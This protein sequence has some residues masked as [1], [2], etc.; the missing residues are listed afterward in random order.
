[1]LFREIFEAQRDQSAI[2]WLEDACSRP[3]ATDLFVHGS[4]FIFDQF[5]EPDT[6]KG[7]LIFTSKLVDDRSRRRLPLQA[8]YYG[9]HLYLVTIDAKKPFR[10]LND[11]TAREIMSQSL[12][13]D[14]WDYESKIK[15]GRLDY[16][17]THLVVPVAVKHGYDLFSIYEVSIQGHSYGCAHSGMLTIVDRL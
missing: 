13:F 7:Q 15:W 16:Q 12:S 8:Q 11:A 3:D 10:P 4:P 1:M 2:K 6:S 5:R 17:D 9:D 14:V